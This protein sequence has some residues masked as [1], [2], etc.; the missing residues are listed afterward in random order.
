MATIPTALRPRLSRKAVA[1]LLVAAL[2]VPLVAGAG[3]IAFSSDGVLGEMELQAFGDVTVVRG[4]EVMSVDETF[5]LEP[6]D[7]ISTGDHASAEFNLVGDRSLELAANSAVQVM[8]AS[9]IGLQEGS[10][11]ATTSEPTRVLVGD[12]EVSASGSDALFRLD[13]MS[14]VRTGVYEGSVQISAPGE[15]SLRIP[16]YFQTSVAVLAPNV[17]SRPAPYSLSGTDAWDEDHLGRILDLNQELTATARGLAGEFRGKA[18]LA[19]FRT[20]AGTDVGFMKPHLKHRPADLLIGLTVA[21]STKSMRLAPAFRKTLDLFERG[22]SWGIAAAIMRA[23]PQTVL[24]SLGDLIAKSGLAG[25]KSGAA[26]ALA[27]NR[28][29]SATGPGAPGGED[30]VGGPTGDP[31]AAPMDDPTD[32]PTRDPDP[33]PTPTPTTTPTNPPDEC[34]NDVECALDDIEPPID[35][36]FDDDLEKALNGGSKKGGGGLGLGDL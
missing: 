25:G 21:E 2:G 30:S 23:R 5:E 8:S 4:G 15:G 29:G 11:L 14:S 17:P 3:W 16:R 10:A 9:A 13:R 33:D 18:P 1:G 27:L 31:T 28:A 26:A 35:N 36:P 24:A 32:D 22:A 12:I 19:Y 6:R 20:V 7:L 34:T